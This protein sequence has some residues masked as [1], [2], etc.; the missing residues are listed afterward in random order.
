MEQVGAG[1][2]QQHCLYMYSNALINRCALR[3]GYDSA[4]MLQAADATIL[5]SIP[6]RGSLSPDDAVPTD[7]WE[8]CSFNTAS[9][10]YV[11]PKAGSFIASG[12]T[13]DVFWYAAH[14]LVQLEGCLQYTNI[15]H[16]LPNMAKQ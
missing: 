3:V 9:D 7:G 6:A 16:S 2:G 11:Q 8:A 5:S 13:A 1:T 10:V 12:T 4:V 15:G 14:V